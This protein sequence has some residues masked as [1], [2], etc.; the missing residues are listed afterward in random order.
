MTLRSYFIL[1]DFTMLFFM[2]QYYKICSQINVLKRMHLKS[3]TE[4]RNFAVFSVICRGT[5]VLN[6]EYLFFCM[7][8]M[9]YQQSAKIL[10]VKYEI[11]FGALP[12]C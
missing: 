1:C 3:M 2:E 9:E 7:Q 6:K 10:L 11:I 8:N 5:N 12:K 4:L